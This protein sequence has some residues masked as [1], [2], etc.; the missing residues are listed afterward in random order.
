MHL[1]NGARWVGSGAPHLGLHLVDERAEAEH[2]GDVDDEAHGVLQR[3]ALRLGDQLHVAERLA[4]AG[5]VAG[6]QRVGAR[7]DAAHAGDE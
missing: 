3:R 5:L 1:D 2:V 4:D 7:I 6:H